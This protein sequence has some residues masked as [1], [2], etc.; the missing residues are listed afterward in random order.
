MPLIPTPK[1]WLRKL[2][3]ERLLYLTLAK[4]RKALARII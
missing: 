4:S 2:L 3:K 1:V